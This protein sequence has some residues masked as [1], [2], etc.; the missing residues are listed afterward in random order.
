MKNEFQ[1]KI[2]KISIIEDSE[3]HRE[4][5]K[6]KLADEIN[7]DAVVSIDRFGRDGIESVKHYKPDVVLLDFQ[8]EDMTGLEVAK[9]LKIHDPKIRVFALTA[10][11]EALII[12]RIISDKNIDAIAIKGSPWGARPL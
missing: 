7:I 5:L 10:H 6:M 3:I 8:L 11:T 2:I 12:Q 4:W 1:N 9:R